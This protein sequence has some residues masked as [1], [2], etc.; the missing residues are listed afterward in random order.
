MKGDL[1]LIKVAEKLGVSF[2]TANELNKI[3]D[4]GLPNRPRFERHEILVGGEVCEVFFRNVIEC[5]RALYG[6]P[7]FAQYL[8]VVPEK[9]YTDEGKTERLFHDMH[10]GRWWWTT[11][12]EVEKKTPGAT[13]V[14]IIISSDK[15]QLTLFRNKTAYP[16]YLTI[17]NIPKE[18]RR[19]PSKRAYILLAYLPVT[20][21]EGVTNKASRRRQLANLYH[22]CLSQILSPLRT[23]G[24]TGLFMASGDGCLRRTHPI[25]ACFIGDYPEQI[26][27]TATKSGCPTC[28]AKPDEL[29][30]FKR[31]G[32]SPWLKD[33][34]QILAVLDSFDGDP[35]GFLQACQGVGLKPVINPFWKDLPYAHVYR[36]IT[37]DV[38]HQLHQGIV[39]HLIGWI[40]DAFGPTEIDARC[41]RMPPNHNIR[42]FLKGI[43]TLSRVTGQEHDQM[44]RILL[45]LVL[46]L[47]LPNGFSNVR[48]IR[49]VRAVLDF[50]CLAQYPVHSAR[51]LELLEEALAS[52]HANK[53][54]FIDLGIRE[55]FNIPKLHFAQHYVRFIRLYGTL[56]N[57]STEYTERLHIDLAKDAYEATNHKDEF[58]QMTV[59]LER[60]EKILRH[61]QY[62]QWRLKEPI[63]PSTSGATPWTSPAFVLD[64]PLSMTKHPSVRA[65]PLTQLATE[66]GAT[67]FREALARFILL[68]NDPET[69]RRDLERNL[70]NVRLPFT[71]LPVWHRIKY[72][73]VD[74]SMI[75][76]I[77]SDSIHCHPQ[78]LDIRGNTIPARFDTALINDGTGADIGVQG[79][80]IG[81]VR[82]IFTLPKAS[83][84]TLFEPGVEVPEHLAFV[85]W[86]SPFT[87]VPERNHGLYKVRPIKDAEGSSVS[88]VIPI[89]N[90]RR[91]VHLF[92]RFGPFAPPEWTSNNVLDLCDTF[93]VNTFTDRHMYRIVI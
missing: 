55:S 18:I 50:L 38:L 61:H 84:D 63:D 60:K 29:G 11:Q 14:P 32:I 83:L 25:F 91:S 40:T 9:H 5:I 73:R 37:P 46:D 93:F 53:E 87:H 52:F 74:P 90:I 28:P 47:P 66:Y 45:G 13:I 30:E 76:P 54:V 22:A 19:K 77:T 56:D 92:P 67:H 44:C 3:I 69:S 78:R 39:K 12:E 17:G 70:W 58:R 64:R 33:L 59:W 72:Q 68:Q 82:V 35:G 80:R 81:R 21:L 88:E 86:F 48:L 85:D 23:A 10:T 26:L 43:T 16:L 31:D 34:D 65:V 36:S 71:K 2:K 75:S 51:T 62:I 27:V 1:P 8:A 42:L 20:K 41:R 49:A 4:E 6:D 15:T 89:A 57:F 24:L 79:Y 7:D